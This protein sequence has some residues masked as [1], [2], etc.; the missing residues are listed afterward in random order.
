MLNHRC[1]LKELGCDHDSAVALFLDL[2]GFCEVRRV[3]FLGRLDK[4]TVVFRHLGDFIKGV[5]H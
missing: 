5:L 4:G 1:S 2:A 3:S